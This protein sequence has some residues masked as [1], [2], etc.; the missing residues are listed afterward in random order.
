MKNLIKAQLYQLKK[1]RILIL[2]FLA[3]CVMQVSG[4]AGEM[5]YEDWKL[6]AGGYLATNGY[7]ILSPV[8]LIVT[9]VTAEVCGADFMDKTG[10]Y[11]LMA[12]YRRKDIFF[13]RTVLSILLSLPAMFLL[14]LIWAVAAVAFGG[15]G[16]ELS[17]EAVLT[18]TV[19]MIFPILRLI[20]EFVFLSYV[21]KNQYIVMGCGLFLF[22]G[23]TVLSIPEH[24][25]MF[26]SVGS[27]H[28]LVSF[29]CWSTFRL[30][31]EKEIR[32]YESAI[33]GSNALGI[34][35]MSVLAGVLFLWLGYQFYKKD[36]LH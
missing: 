3:L 9:L 20:C 22:M 5:A 2:I 36:D 30:V 33:S 10:N 35:V 12:G 24:T 8:I 13:S 6:S 14:L 31:D 4:S 17:P 16:T 32:I 34:V 28:E 19:L 29:S 18:R 21:I 15:W 7:V 27:I 25:R 23:N 26:S 11:E 1:N